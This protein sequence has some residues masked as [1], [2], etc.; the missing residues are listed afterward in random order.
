M[1]NKA[2]PLEGLVTEADVL[3]V[4]LRENSRLQLEKAELEAIVVKLLSVIE[5]VE[6]GISLGGNAE[7]V[8]A[9]KH[10]GV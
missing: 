4:I 6:G 5:E 10:N 9:K 7:Q 8:E 2:H 3:E 1:E